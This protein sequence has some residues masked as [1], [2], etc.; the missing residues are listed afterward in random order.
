MDIQFI[1][2]YLP[3]IEK[4]KTCI[5][6]AKNPMILKSE[7]IWSAFEKFKNDNQKIIFSQKRGGCNGFCDLNGIATHE[8][9]I[10]I[11][12]SRHKTRWHKNV[13]LFRTYLLTKF[14]ICFYLWYGTLMPHIAFT[15]SSIT[16]HI[17][18]TFK[19]CAW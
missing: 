1:N 10:F 5:V 15:H 17:E 4:F 14:L 12:R 13:S 6:T 8:F 11:R 2:N 9:S 16:F 7:R 19:N 3:D 18:Y